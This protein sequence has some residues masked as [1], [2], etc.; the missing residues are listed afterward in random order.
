MA[1][2]VRAVCVA[3]VL[4]LSSCGDGGGDDGASPGTAPSTTEP[5]AATAAQPGRAPLPDD[6]CQLFTADEVAGFVGLDPGTVA[7]TDASDDLCI[8]VIPGGPGTGRAVLGGAVKSWAEIEQTVDHRVDA[9]AQ[10]EAPGSTLTSTDDPNL[11]I[12]DYD[13]AG[14]DN[15]QT[16]AR[17]GERAVL[18]QS[19]EVERAEMRG[20]A[21][22]LLA[23]YEA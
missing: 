16:V 9:G 20:L 19:Q 18:L 21:E 2:T 23:R 22:E 3:A 7:A 13:L 17:F 14:V 10:A 1:A 15:P 8:W 11:F 5:A 12:L 6:P 4:I